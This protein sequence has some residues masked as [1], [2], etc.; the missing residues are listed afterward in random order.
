[1]FR[2]ERNTRFSSSQKCDEDAKDPMPVTL[3]I[4]SLG[5]SRDGGVCKW[6]DNEN[7]EAVLEHRL[8]LSRNFPEQN[9]EQAQAIQPATTLL[10]EYA[11]LALALTP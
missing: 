8:R 7:T 9:L 6:L 4:V 3:Y 11:R 10:R 1:M 5:V 2:A